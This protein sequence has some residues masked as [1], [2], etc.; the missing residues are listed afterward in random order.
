M[1][2]LIPVYVCVV[3]FAFQGSLVMGLCFGRFPAEQPKWEPSTVVFLSL[4]AL[5]L[6]GIPS[7]SDFLSP[8]MKTPQETLILMQFVNHGPVAAEKFL[9]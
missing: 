7:S 9:Q 5:L 3:G 6:P 8:S 1:N 4:G 2:E